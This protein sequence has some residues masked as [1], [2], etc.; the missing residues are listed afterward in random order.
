MA[1]K[2]YI[3]KF[4]VSGKVPAHTVRLENAG[5]EFHIQDREG[6]AFCRLH[7]TRTG[8]RI[9]KPNIELKNGKFKTWEDILGYFYS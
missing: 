1:K 5:V 9:A 6:K 3:K 4:T 7:V 8:V 2:R